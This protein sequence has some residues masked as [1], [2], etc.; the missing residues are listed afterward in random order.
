M[1]PGETTDTMVLRVDWSGY[2]NQ[3]L[4]VVADD[5]EGLQWVPECVEDNNE[6]TFETPDCSS[7]S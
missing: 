3:N 6:A 7:G 1:A 2:D 4:V 5:D